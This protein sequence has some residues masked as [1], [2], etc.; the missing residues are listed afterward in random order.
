M[1]GPQATLRRAQDYTLG[2]RMTEDR[3]S[4]QGSFQLPCAGQTADSIEHWVKTEVAPGT[5]VGSA[6]TSLVSFVVARSGLRGLGEWSVERH[7]VAADYQVPLAKGIP[8]LAVLDSD[9]KLLYSQTNGEWE[10]A[11]SMDPA[12]IITFLDKWKP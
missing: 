12:D 7:D 4:G 10:S 9:G 8:A 5:I 6:K 2:S 1:A 11:R 3:G